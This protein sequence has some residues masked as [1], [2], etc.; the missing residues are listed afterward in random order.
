[1]SSLDQPPLQHLLVVEIGGSVAAPY[2]A[3]VLSDLGARV[4]KVER[5]VGD[6]ARHWGPPFWEGAA[7]FFQALNRNK[8][9]VVCDLRSAEQAQALRAFILEQ[10]DVVVQNL[11]PGQV[12]ALG[13][14]AAELR[15]AKPD[16]VYVDMGAYG[17]AA[18]AWRER[19][20]YDPLMQAEAG[21]MSVTGHEGAPPN[22]VGPSI[23]D[24][25][26]GL[27]AV[28]GVLAALLRRERQ[29]RGAHVQVS[30]FETA[31]ALM[32]TYVAQYLAG[33]VVPRKQ[34]SGAN[35][36]APYRAFAARDG[37]LVIAAGNDKLFRLLCGV[38]GL[39]DLP[40]DPR[41]A[42]NAERVRHQ[43]E[44]EPLLEQRI[45]EWPRAQLLDR[46]AAA[47]VPS[48]PVNDT[49]GLVEHPQLQ[50]LGLLQVLPDSELRAIGLPLRLD[51]QRPQPRRRPPRLGEHTRAVLGQEETS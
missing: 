21:I 10:A 1:M 14:G 17:E 8:E 42:S 15:A 22:R 37:D 3:M 12:Q 18:G 20:G 33:G 47:G 45:G 32:S 5:A 26:T 27:W 6:D 7:A 31:A 25:G 23:I 48:A 13:L 46:L 24:M 11:R 16:L 39:E 29:R 41:F 19:A 38:L 35:G 30:L 50:A 28:V 34:G 4:V 43:R 49:R 40:A 44:L 9:S 2:A 51:G 36:I